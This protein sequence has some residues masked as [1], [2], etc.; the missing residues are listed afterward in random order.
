MS[1]EKRQTKSN[2]VGFA[3][4]SSW[5]KKI[6]RGK[7]DEKKFNTLVAGKE[8]T[9]LTAVVTTE[10]AVGEVDGMEGEARRSKRV[11]KRRVDSN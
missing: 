1:L 11:R 4:R 5:K 6:E 9:N 7:C 2:I 8:L 10:R 3:F